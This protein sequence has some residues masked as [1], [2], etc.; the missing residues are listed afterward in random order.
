MSYATS[1]A[2]SAYRPRRAGGPGPIFGVVLRPQTYRNLLYHVASL[3]LGVFYFV[4]LVAGLATGVSSAV[5]WI[6]IP[7]LLFMIAA[8]WGLASFERQLAIWWLGVEIR[9]MSRP[10]A[11]GP[12]LFARFKAHLSNQVTWTSLVYL[13]VKFPLG[14]L[15]FALTVGLVGLTARLVSA[16][17]APLI[18]LASGLPLD[19]ADLTVRLLWCA[20]GLVVG[21]VSLHLLNGL[22]FVS[23][24]FARL[25]LG[26]TDTAERLSQTEALAE[27]EHAKAE[28]ADRSQ[29]DLIVNASHEL[30][31]P[32]ASIRGYAESLLLA[33]DA[34]ERAQPGTTASPPELRPYLGVIQ[35]EAT[36]LGTLVDEILALARAEADDLRLDLAPVAAGEVVEEV[37]QTMAPLAKRERS[38]TVVH[39]V[40]PDLPRVW[41]DR[42]RFN[43]VLQNLVRNAI[44]YTPPGGIVSLTLD[45]VPGD[46][47]HLALTVADT[48]AGIPPADLERIF[49]RFYRADAS[50]ARASGGFG[51]GLAIV[52]DLV[53]KMG[54]TIEV[55]STVGVGSTFRVVLLVTA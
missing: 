28:R 52:R 41:A 23:G 4:F 45:R 47:R 24:R 12:G 33:L 38:I 53:T 10:R 15:S 19:P 43:Q 51:L 29:R 3:P 17:L 32:V 7:I 48:G 13:L 5:A 39:E 42:Q 14:V 21:L 50:R 46:D 30:R 35:R 36:R 40:A 55:E 8:W 11:T 31:T 25:M 34:Q 27:R 9:P 1:A 22:A 6:G 37:Y 44:A 26:L 54:G 18:D 2:R 16:P 49:E 20:L